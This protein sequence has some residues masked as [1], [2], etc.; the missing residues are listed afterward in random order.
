MDV[1]RPA[2]LNF[3]LLF[4][5]KKTDFWNKVGR[6]EIA[7]VTEKQVKK[8]SVEGKRGGGLACIGEAHL[9]RNGS[10]CHTLN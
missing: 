9:Q 6:K 7:A 4:L 3:L 2:S 5:Y 1:T 8:G 10:A